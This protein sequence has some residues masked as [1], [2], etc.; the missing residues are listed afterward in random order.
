MSKERAI[1]T[2]KSGKNEAVE[3][4]H[5]WIFSGA[6]KKVHGYPKEGDI[7]EVQSNKEEFLGIGHWQDGS[8]AVR[9]FDF[10]VSVI[11][12]DYWETKIN[13][14]Y[15][16]RKALGLID[17]PETNVYRLIYAEGDYMPG[18]VVDIYN[19]TAVIQSHSIGMHYLRNEIR[20]A[21]ISVYGNRIETIYYK[22]EDSLPK[23]VD[24]E[25]H[26]EFL[27]GSKEEDVVVENGRKFLVNWV[28]GQK[29]GFFIDQ[30]FNR[31]LVSKYSKGRKVLNTYC[32]TGGFSIYALSSGA[33]FVHSVDSSQKAIELTDKNVVLNGHT[34]NHQS[35]KI[36]AMDYLNEM[37]GKFDLI[38]LDPPAFAKHKDVKHRAVQGYKRINA[39]ALQKI[40]PGGILFTFSCSQ[41]VDRRLFEA[42]VMSAAIQSG[43]KVKV[44]HHLSQPADHPY[45]IFHQEGE[46]LKGL[47]LYVE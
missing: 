24:F 28:S 37:D 34:S 44:L 45:S 3:R 1:V 10:E 31:E 32:Y 47:V 46:Y 40:N 43:R 15:K 14:P 38:I 23:N 33:E 25:K 13:S 39:T 2:L 5:P 20:D 8:I 16:H 36:D 19:K 17:N 9:I 6:I 22:C 35:I 4:Q 18:L 27:F 41:V 7:V 42:T 29:T 26:D 12:P 21:L 30:R 11:G